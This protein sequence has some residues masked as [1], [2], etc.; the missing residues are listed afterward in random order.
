[1]QLGANPNCVTHGSLMTPIITA[2]ILG[3]TES[4]MALIESGADINA[5]DSTRSNALMHAGANGNDECVRALLE[6][7][8]WQVRCVCYAC[9]SNVI[10]NFCD[11]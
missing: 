9:H 2:C 3:S 6:A 4:T 5:F 1:M 7:G 11:I 10:G 8:K